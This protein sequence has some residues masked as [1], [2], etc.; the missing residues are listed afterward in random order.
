MRP[1]SEVRYG[2]LQGTRRA[3]VRFH[4]H[5]SLE[6]VFAAFPDLLA[7]SQWFQQRA[8]LSGESVCQLCACCHVKSRKLCSVLTY[9]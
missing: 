1:E 8:R 7:S 4:P 2:H 6:S 3:S 9:C 5:V